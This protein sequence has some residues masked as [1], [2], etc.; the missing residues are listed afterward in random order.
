MFGDLNKPTVEAMPRGRFT[1]EKST[2]VSTVWRLSVHPHGHAPSRRTSSRVKRL[3]CQ[4]GPTV[5]LLDATWMLRM[6]LNKAAELNW[7]KAPGR[8]A[9]GRPAQWATCMQGVLNRQCS[10]AHQEKS[11]QAQ[12]F[13]HALQH[14]PPTSWDTIQ[15][16]QANDIYWRVI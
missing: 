10:T 14:N 15:L 8:A 11:Q 9:S 6:L 1:Y 5:R 12:I 4:W 2:A 7:P 16:I 3:L 13:L